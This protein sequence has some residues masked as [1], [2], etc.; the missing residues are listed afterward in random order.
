[1][2]DVD[3]IRITVIS[4]FISM[5]TETVENTTLHQQQQPGG[6]GSPVQIIVGITSPPRNEAENYV[7]D[8]RSNKTTDENVSVAGF[9]QVT[10]LSV[11][12]LCK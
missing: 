2:V 9:D 10:S 8:D 4:S 5:G 7:Q 11:I 1:M 6:Q 12:F 3:D